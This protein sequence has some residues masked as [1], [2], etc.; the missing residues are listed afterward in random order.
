MNLESRKYTV[1]LAKG[2]GMIDETM[3]L[4]RLWEPGMT[5]AELAN[6]AIQEGAFARGTA[7]RIKDMVAEQFGPRFIGNGGRAGKQIK[8]LIESGCRSQNLGQIFFLHTARANDV[9]YD[10]VC[11][12][13]WPL[14]EAGRDSLGKTEALNFLRI[15]ADNGRIPSRWSEIMMNRIASYLGGC[16]AD[17]GLLENSK[18]SPRRILP[19]KIDRLT[20]LY[21]AHDIHFGSLSDNQVIDHRDWCLFG[22]KRS[23]VT[24]ELQLVSNGHFIPQFSGDLVR[25]SWRYKDLEEAFHAIGRAEL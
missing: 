8:V 16:L 2:Q 19:F 11:E 5:S 3:A 1:A 9:L 10:F 14:Y 12:A 18:R 4:F 21:L 23:D 6:R 17:F 13:Y 24:R 15:A 22:M 20:A 7:K 25:I